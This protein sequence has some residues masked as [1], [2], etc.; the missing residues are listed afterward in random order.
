MHAV[1]SKVQEFSTKTGKQKNLKNLNFQALRAAAHLLAE[2][3][4]PPELG[5]LAAVRADSDDSN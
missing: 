4:L 3:G 2:A 1:R 5:R